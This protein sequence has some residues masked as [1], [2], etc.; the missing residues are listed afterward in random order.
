MQGT[1]M[2]ETTALGT[3]EDPKDTGPDVALTEEELYQDLEP[4]SHLSEVSVSVREL[5]DTA[6]ESPDFLSA[7]AAPEITEYSWPPMYLAIWSILCRYATTPGLFKW[8]ALGLPRGFIKTTFI[9]LYVVWCILYSRKKFILILSENLEKA[10]NIIADIMDMLSEPNMVRI[11]GS[12]K[13]TATTDTQK[14]K[15]FTFRG[16]DIIIGGRRGRS[17]VRGLNIKNAAQIS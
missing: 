14:L 17:S 12:W 8:F 6:R 15:K 3:A 16:R 7:I 13:E 5:V 10:Q 4:A 11:F 9:K 2:S 1:I